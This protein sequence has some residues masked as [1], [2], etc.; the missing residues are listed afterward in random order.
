MRV[1]QYIR[2][3]VG[4]FIKNHIGDILGFGRCPI[5]RDTFWNTELASVPYVH[6]KG[7]LVSAR[8]L[9]E[10]PADQIASTVHRSRIGEQSLRH[11]SIEEITAK[12]PDECF[13]IPR[14]R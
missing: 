10:M 1:I 8:V 4:P 12:I 3:Q 7:S 13:I 6:N 5:T 2:N 9:T 11:Y 14:K